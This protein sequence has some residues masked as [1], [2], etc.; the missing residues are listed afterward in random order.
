MKAVFVETT[1]FTQELPQYLT[2][3]AYA[4]IQHVLMNNPHAGA[5]IRGCG[6]LRK[7]RVPDRRRG[8][9]KRGGA[10]IIYLYVPE[11]SRFLMLDIYGKDEQDDLTAV[12]RRILASL[13]AEYRQSV[14]AAQS[15]RSRG[16]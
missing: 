6:G 7:V 14:I 13:A 12:E 3:A 2:D 9:G 10:R 15:Q 8:K 1:E 4:A 16:K 5:V 11:A